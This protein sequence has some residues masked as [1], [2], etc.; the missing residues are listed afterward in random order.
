MNEKAKQY[1]DN[2]AF[3][4]GHLKLNGFSGISR[5]E[6][7]AGIIL[8]GMVGMGPNCGNY[9][10]TVSDALHYADLLLEELTK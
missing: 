8:S 3:P 7:F 2:P 6:Y 10:R 5:R 9:E 4:T 1:G